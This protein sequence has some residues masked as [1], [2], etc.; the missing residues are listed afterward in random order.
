MR[1]IKVGDIVMVGGAA[2]P[3]MR[4]L[5]AGRFRTVLVIHCAGSVIKSDWGKAKVLEDLAL[6]DGEMTFRLRDGVSVDSP[7]F[8]ACYLV[9]LDAPGEG[10]FIDTE[11]DAP[12]GVTA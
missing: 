3:E 2:E 9:P 10:Q 4:R 12:V 6:L 11:I 5:N 1:P 8:P 7:L